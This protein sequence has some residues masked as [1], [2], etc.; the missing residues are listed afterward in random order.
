MQIAFELFCDTNIAVTQT[1]HTVITFQ[2]AARMRKTCL[3]R[4]I[5]Q[6]KIFF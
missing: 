2:Y 5:F 6:D 1:L 4:V 3:Q